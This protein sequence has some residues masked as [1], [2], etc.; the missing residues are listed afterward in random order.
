MV[1]AKETRENKS[2]LDMIQTKLSYDA[3]LNDYKSGDLRAEIAEMLKKLTKTITKIET[4]DST[5]VE[6]FFS[7]CVQYYYLFTFLSITAV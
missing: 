2:A 4:Q 5:K 6:C 7:F 1:A 3:A